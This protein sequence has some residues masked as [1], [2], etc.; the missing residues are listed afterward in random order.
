MSVTVQIKYGNL[1]E[2]FSGE[3]N[4]VWTS[5]N[6]F[7]CQTIPV[8]RA[9]QDAVLTVN[10]KQVIDASRGLVAAAE[11]GPVVLIP[12]RKL[13]DSESLL[14]ML[15]AAFLGGRLGVLK[16]P[17]LSKDEVQGWLGK[18]AKITGTRLAELCRE[19]FT[20]RTQDGNYQLTTYGVKH[21]V[22]VLLPS[23]RKKL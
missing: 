6:R 23:I 3:V 5:V 21:L 10:L 4:Q 12:K 15:L 7:F 9:V 1:E 19:G 13:T 22:E 8:F 20:M 14:L 2:T 18:T 16:K 11:E 17:W